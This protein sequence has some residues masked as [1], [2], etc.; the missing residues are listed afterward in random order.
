MRIPMH[1]LESK[2]F[3]SNTKSIS[4]DKSAAMEN[5]E[6]CNAKQIVFSMLMDTLFHVF[7]NPFVQSLNHID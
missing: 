1:T 7:Q 6:K 3:H 4:Q 5:T 2:Q